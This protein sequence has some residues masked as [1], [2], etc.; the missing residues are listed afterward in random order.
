MTFVQRGRHRRILRKP[1]PF[2]CVFVSELSIVFSSFGAP[3]DYYS[4]PVAP[5]AT[6]IDSPGN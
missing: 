4:T 6:V 3:P 5:K 2:F 1:H